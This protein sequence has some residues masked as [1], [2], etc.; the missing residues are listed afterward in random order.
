MAQGAVD[1]TGSTEAATPAAAA[2]DLEEIHATKFTAGGLETADH[3]IG[4]QAGE[5]RWGDNSWK[6]GGGGETF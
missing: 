1:K 4:I 6:A 3:G 5:V 2:I